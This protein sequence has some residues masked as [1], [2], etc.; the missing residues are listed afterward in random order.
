MIE[1]VMD[2]DVIGKGVKKPSYTI[3][4]LHKH[5]RLGVK[6][7]LTLQFK[8]IKVTDTAKGYDFEN[9][10]S[11]IIVECLQIEITEETQYKSI[12]YFTHETE[13]QII[14]SHME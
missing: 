4:D 13:H 10:C 5:F 9:S 3:E 7:K 6:C 8:S 2:T 12:D 11:Q 14:G 1:D